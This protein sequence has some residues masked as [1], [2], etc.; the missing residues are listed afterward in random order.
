MMYSMKLIQR[1]PNNE[2]ETKKL[3]YLLSHVISLSLQFNMHKI[4]YNMRRKKV[5]V[6]S[7]RLIFTFEW[8]P[9]NVNSNER[10]NSQNKL[11]VNTYGENWFDNGRRNECIDFWFIQQSYQ[12]CSRYVR[13][14]YKCVCEI[15]A[16]KIKK[17]ILALSSSSVAFTRRVECA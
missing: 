14:I 11:E 9:L 3:Q 15:K 12:S 2:R 8:R 1:T 16:L 13:G 6:A 10:Q 17:K 4:P 5:Y 7:Y